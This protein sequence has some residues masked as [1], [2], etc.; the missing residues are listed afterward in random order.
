MAEASNGG[1]RVSLSVAVLGPLV[2]VV[3]WLLA[4]RFVVGTQ[5]TAVSVRVAVVE[6]DFRHFRDLWEVHMRDHRSIE[7]GL[8][9]IKQRQNQVF[10]KLKMSR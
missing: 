1:R 4:D 2:A 9:T 8:S 5:L 7:E 6:E 10:D 3:L